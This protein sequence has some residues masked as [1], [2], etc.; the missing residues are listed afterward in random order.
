MRL[1]WLPA[2]LALFLLTC[3]TQD[4]NG[5][6]ETTT[7]TTG[8]ASVA[9]AAP[10]IVPAPEIKAA[11]AP[12]SGIGD[13]VVE[14][15]VPI[16]RER[17]AELPERERVD[18][19]LAGVSAGWSDRLGVDPVE[20][21]G[22]V[23]AGVNLN[24]GVEGSGWFDQ[25]AAL[26]ELQGLNGTEATQKWIDELGEGDERI[27]VNGVT[28]VRFDEMGLDVHFGN[29][30]AAVFR[31]IAGNQA[32]GIL[33]GNAE[34]NASLEATLA[35]LAD[36]PIKAAILIPEP[37]KERLE[38]F[39]SFTLSG[40]NVSD[41]STQADQTA[42]SAALSL[43]QGN[44]STNRITVARLQSLIQSMKSVGVAIDM[45][46]RTIVVSMALD[47][48][49]ADSAQLVKQTADLVK[50]IPSNNRINFLVN[51]IAS[52]AGLDEDL[53]GLVRKVLP[54]LGTIE[55]EVDGTTARVSID[56]DLDLLLEVAEE[57]MPA[58]S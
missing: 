55:S 27:E 51:Q 56:L 37:T 42:V 32:S 8:D 11:Q 43:L 3:G 24:I 49:D 23:R 53:L 57:F 30:G 38:R 13:V 21:L 1:L 7:D 29:N 54:V 15:N 58:Q 5:N 16:V 46:D 9:T 35:M 17:V 41:L 14:V 36:A 28:G 45:A 50:S 18:T 44:A 26:I 47:M 48:E 4:S 12:V 34:S 52:G 39:L 25:F 22:M 40:G 19:W 31:G 6:D 10:A 20:A 33:N 2:I